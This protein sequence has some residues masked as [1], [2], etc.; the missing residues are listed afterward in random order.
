MAK[1]WTAEVLFYENNKDHECP[2]WCDKMED[3]MY[4]VQCT[5]AALQKSHIK[6]WTDFQ[7]FT[8]N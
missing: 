5:A 4:Y 3:G 2:T 1:L 8:T 7:K 6:R